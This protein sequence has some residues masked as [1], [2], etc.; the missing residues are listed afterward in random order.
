M[1]PCVDFSEGRKSVKRFV[2]MSSY[3]AI[4][5]ILVDLRLKKCQNT[6]PLGVNIKGVNNRELRL[7]LLKDL[8]I[9]LPSAL[10]NQ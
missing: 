6:G 8:I 10:A 7:Y 3:E 5:R 4:M 1:L 2:D 9:A